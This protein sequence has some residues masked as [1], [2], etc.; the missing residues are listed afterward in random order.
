MTGLKDPARL[1]AHFASDLIDVM[2]VVSI[3]EE[4]A[5]IEADNSEHLRNQA[6]REWLLGILMESLAECEEPQATISLLE[7]EP[8]DAEGDH[9]P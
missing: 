8:D 6:D 1:Q 5:D 3:G 2:Y 9:H 7:E 4:T